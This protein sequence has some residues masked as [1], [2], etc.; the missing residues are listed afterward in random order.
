MACYLGNIGRARGYCVGWMGLLLSSCMLSEEEEE[1]LGG[2][3]LAILSK[4][5]S[6]Q[7][8]EGGEEEVPRA[9]QKRKEEIRF[10]RAERNKVPSSYVFFC[11]SLLSGEI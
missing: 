8:E 5:T 7:K 9:L 4:E 3:K 6:K 10:V 1:R 11:M 2:G